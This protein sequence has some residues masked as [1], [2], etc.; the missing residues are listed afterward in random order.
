MAVLF[1][2]LLGGLLGGFL[3]SCGEKREEAPLPESAVEGLGDAARAA[4]DQRLGRAAD[5]ADGVVTV[6]FRRKALL[7]EAVVEFPRKFEGW[8][9]FAVPG[10]M[11]EAPEREWLLQVPAGQW[12]PVI[13]WLEAESGTAAQLQGGLPAG[14]SSGFLRVH[15]VLGSEEEE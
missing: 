12:K 4:A 14:R 1:G 5:L 6:S 2:G 9:V 7:E 11:S 3:A 8:D 13:E 10:E 15:F